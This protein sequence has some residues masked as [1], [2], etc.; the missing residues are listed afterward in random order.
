VERATADDTDA[1]ETRLRTLIHEEV[2]AAV[3]EV[4]AS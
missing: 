3:H 4:L 2:R 1:A